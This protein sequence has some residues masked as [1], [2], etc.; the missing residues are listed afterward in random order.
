M[1]GGLAHHLNPIFEGGI[2]L[3]DLTNEE[4]IEV[5]MALQ[6]HIRILE[7]KIKNFESKPN[8]DVFQRMLEHAKTHLGYANAALA[9]SR[10]QMLL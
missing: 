6:I 2:S 7:E 10:K 9:K 4:S 3:L 8:D 1:V 5:E